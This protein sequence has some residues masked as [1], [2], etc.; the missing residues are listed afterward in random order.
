MILVHLK[1]YL[2]AI[3]PALLLAAC[4]TS[5]GL[6]LPA[7]ETGRK[8][9]EA[10]LKP[11]KDR[12]FAY[13]TPLESRNGG[14]WLRVPYDENRDINQRDE[15][16]VRKARS[17]YITPLPSGSTL[18]TTYETPSGNQAVHALG[19]VTGRSAMTVIYLHGRDGNRDW[20]FDDERF[21][22]NYN[23]L[24][25]LLLEAGGAYFSPDFTDFGKDGAADIAGLVRKQ[26]PLTDGR[27]ILACGSMG[28]LVCW[29]LA[30]N[31]EL[32]AMIDGLVL[33]GGFPDRDFLRASY[34]GA[35]SPIPVYIA[36]GSADSVYP[37]EDME[38]F[39]GALNAKN[40]PVRMTVFDSGNHGTPVRMIDWRQ[41][42]NWIA[43]ASTR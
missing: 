41:T 1:R 32:A 35:I 2:A 19:R 25:N 15:I 20:G 21:G 26:R 9:Y 24:K 39:F 29:D 18:D 42:L 11:F 40:L 5:D 33:L 16:P 37:V 31:A 38:D 12:L 27:L 4:Q 36:H 3:L 30:S 23:R 17:S 34:S 14:D 8:Q 6:K 43:A 7:S 13:R 22:G 10:P 28:A